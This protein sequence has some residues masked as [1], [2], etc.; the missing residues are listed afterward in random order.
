M[1]F[2]ITQNSNLQ[3]MEF[4][5]YGWVDAGPLCEVHFDGVSLS[6]V[7][8]FWGRQWMCVNRFELYEKLNEFIGM[9]TTL[10]DVSIISAWLTDLFGNLLKPLVRPSY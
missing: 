5:S 8:V 6:S 7:L 4:L 3:V 2:Y 9:T 10:E 1:F